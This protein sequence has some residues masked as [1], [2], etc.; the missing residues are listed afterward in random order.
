MRRRWL[1]ALFCCRKTKK[2]RLNRSAS[3]LFY[4][5]SGL[6]GCVN[7]NLF[8]EFLVFVLDS[9]LSTFPSVSELNGWNPCFLNSSS[10][11]IAVF[12]LGVRT[13]CKSKELT[14]P[15]DNFAL[16]ITL[17]DEK[18][19]MCPIKDFL[20]FA[21]RND[22]FSDEVIGK[23]NDDITFK[24]SMRKKTKQNRKKTG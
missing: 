11:R 24:T 8:L 22:G 12:C 2:R 18:S 4:L 16:F 13:F 14:Q 6:W 1:S 20:T 3:Y 17:S 7:V 9:S 19:W 23:Q 15:I 10:W 21:D 5:V